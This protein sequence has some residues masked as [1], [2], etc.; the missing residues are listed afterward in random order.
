MSHSTEIFL[1]DDHPIVRNGLKALIE[2]LGNYKVT[3]EYDNGEELMNDYPFA[4]PPS[5]IIM[6]LMMP[7]MD[8]T[9]TV[10]ALKKHNAKYPV[11]MLTL[12]TDERTIINLFRMGIRGYLPKS[13]TAEVLRKAISDVLTTGFYHNEM[14]AKALLSVDSSEPDERQ[15]IINQVSGR[16]RDFLKLVCDEKEPTYEQIAEIMAVSR[17]T[18]DGYRES[19]FNKFNIKSKTGLVMFAIKYGIVKPE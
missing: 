3:G 11:L 18:V 9:E 7:V 8:G 1:V 17:R 2:R 4:H 19:L 16:E 12:E 15:A 6:D 14:L 10:A 13:S 5:L